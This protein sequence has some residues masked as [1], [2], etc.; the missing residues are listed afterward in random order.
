[1]GSAMTVAVVCASGLGKSKE[2]LRAFAGQFT[3]KMTQCLAYNRVMTEL[4]AR[5][6]QVM[7]EERM[8]DDTLS[9]H[10]R[11]WEA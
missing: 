7:S 4:K 5:G 6:F 11:R 9:I 1:M 3:D 10:V 8:K 2:E